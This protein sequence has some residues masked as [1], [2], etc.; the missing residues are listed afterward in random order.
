V[1]VPMYYGLVVAFTENLGDD[2]QSLAALQFYP[3]VDYIIHREYINKVRLDEP[4]KV[5]LNGWYMSKPWNWPPSP[6]IIPLI[7]SFH[8]DPW[9][10]RFILNPK[11]VRYLKRFEPIGTRDS[12]TRVLLK[13]KGIDSYL[14]LCLTL[15]IDKGYR[16]LIGKRSDNVV[17]VDVPAVVSRILEEKIPGHEFVSFSQSI[18]DLSRFEKF[19]TYKILKR[20]DEFIDGIFGRSKVLNLAGL[21]YS[22]LIVRRGSRINLLERFRDALKRLYIL[23]SAGIV[24]TTRLH[25]ALPSVALGTPTI[26]LVN[27]PRDP[28][29]LDYTRI[30][31]NYEIQRFP[32]LAKSI[33]DYDDLV[34][35]AKPK[36]P[37]TIKEAKQLLTI[38][39][40]RFLKEP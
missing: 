11:G 32:N 15:T 13:E 26:L 30:I 20:I 22:G 28:R 14:S 39:I 7:I 6:S 21:T 4:I 5:V 17:L 1:G 34:E 31:A 37:D 18:V 33:N 3:R 19:I 23:A 16:F 35:I 40:E 24:I 2:I 8:T 25:I 12:Y 27:D 29:L 38:K 9:S 36:K 10:A